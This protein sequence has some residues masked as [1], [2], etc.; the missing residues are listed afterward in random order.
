MGLCLGRKEE[1]VTEHEEAMQKIIKDR[2]QKLEYALRADYMKWDNVNTVGSSS[3]IW[4]DGRDLNFIRNR[5]IVDRKRMEEISF[6]PECYF[7]EIPEVKPLTYMV[8]PEEI[9]SQAETALKEIM[10]DENYHYVYWC[11]RMI[12]KEQQMETGAA[13]ILSM[14]EKLENGIKVNDYLIMKRYCDFENVKKKSLVCRH[15]MEEMIAEYK[16]LGI[17]KEFEHVDEKVSIPFK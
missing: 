16:D 2:N 4:T 17:M 1:N 15:L 12:S 9:K 10:S 6:F 8:R 5:I 14:V 11:L 13:E 7:W 3:P